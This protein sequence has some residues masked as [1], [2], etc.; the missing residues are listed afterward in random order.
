[1]SQILC[2]RI[3]KNFTHISRVRNELILLEYDDF[4]IIFQIRF[5]FQSSDLEVSDIFFKN[6]MWFPE[7]CI[8]KLL[9]DIYKMT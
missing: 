2:V 9:Q 4:S 8:L 7:N 1:M 5:Q 3:C 6:R